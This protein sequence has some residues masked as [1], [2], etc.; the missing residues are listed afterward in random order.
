MP[1]P[2]IDLDFPPEENEWEVKPMGNAIR[3]RKP[4][5]WGHFAGGGVNPADTRFID[6]ALREVLAG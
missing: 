2:E 6:D 5:V 3:R 4:G 1:S